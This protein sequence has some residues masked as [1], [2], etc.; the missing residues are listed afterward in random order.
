MNK[1]SSTPQSVA[2]DYWEPMWRGKPITHSDDPLV[3]TAETWCN[4]KCQVFIYDWESPEG[5]PPIVNLSIKLNNRNH[6]HDWRD[7]YRIKTELCG[8]MS[9][10]FELYPDQQSLVDTANQY[11]M[12]VCAPGFRFPV[13]LKQRGITDYSE[14]FSNSIKELKQSHGDAFVEEM[15]GRSKQ[16]EWYE[17]HKCDGLHP[18]GP[19]WAARG[20]A[21]L[22]DKV[23][24][25]R[26]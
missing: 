1:E 13:S 12:F 16:R 18:I 20:Y 19:V 5:W 2:E 10:G 26:V 4:N 9:W 3:R 23:V 6:W 25:F 21:L 22:D 8:T 14:E 15:M 11:H 24:R 17:H 7:F